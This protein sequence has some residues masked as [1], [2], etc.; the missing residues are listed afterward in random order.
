MAQR[1]KLL[2]HKIEKRIEARYEVINECLES[3]YQQLS[4][5]YASIESI[6]MLYFFKEDLKKEER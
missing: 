2:Q 5:I 3:I 4:E 6:Q 1:G